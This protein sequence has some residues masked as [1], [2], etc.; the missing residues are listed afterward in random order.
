MSRLT[1]TSSR[2]ISTN[3][4]RPNGGREDY[5]IYFGDV[6]NGADNTLVNRTDTY[7]VVKVTKM[8]MK[9]RPTSCRVHR[10]DSI[11][12]NGDGE[13]QYWKRETMK[14]SHS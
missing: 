9:L 12:L 7:Y 4:R 11:S 3:S 2:A 5:T 6:N 1:M 13:N 10:C 14:A 8:A